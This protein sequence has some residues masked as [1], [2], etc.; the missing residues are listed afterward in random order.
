[1]LRPLGSSSLH[2]NSQLDDDDYENEISSILGESASF[3][4]EKVVAVVILLRVLVVIV[5]ETSYQRSEALSSLS[6]RE[7]A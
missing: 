4:R 1:M 2:V 6:D 3:W 5:T 7:R